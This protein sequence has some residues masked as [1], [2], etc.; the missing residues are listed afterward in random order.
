MLERYSHTRQ[1]AKK[2]AVTGLDRVEVGTKL[3]TAAEAAAEEES[4]SILE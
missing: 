3:G 1:A 2:I 4:V